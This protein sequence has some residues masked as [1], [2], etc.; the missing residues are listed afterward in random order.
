MNIIK[1]I[2]DVIYET[3]ES[4]CAFL[5]SKS[6]FYLCKNL[7]K[8][9]KTGEFIGTVIMIYILVKRVTKY[10]N[11]LVNSSSSFGLLVHC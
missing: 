1:H 3:F 9:I 11:H 5:R 4:F 7:K 6:L 2:L 10:T 8:Q